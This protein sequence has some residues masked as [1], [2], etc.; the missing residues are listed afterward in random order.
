MIVVGAA[1]KIISGWSFTFSPYIL[2][3]SL[4]HLRGNRRVLQV[5]PGATLRCIGGV[6]FAAEVDNVSWPFSLLMHLLSAKNTIA[7]A[8]HMTQKVSF[9][10]VPPMIIGCSSCLVGASLLRAM[11]GGV[12]AVVAR[13]GN[14]VVSLLIVADCLV[15]RRPI[16][17]HGCLRFL[18]F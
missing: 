14:C 7:L 11:L 13:Q 12:F 3:E 2:P 15:C 9:V 18:W 6:L 16:S 4:P 17:A 1:R 10:D 5:V 8:T